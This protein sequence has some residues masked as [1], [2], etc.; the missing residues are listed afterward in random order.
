MAGITFLSLTQMGYKIKQVILE[1]AVVIWIFC[2]Y[3]CLYVY[4]WS[5]QE[6]KGGKYTKK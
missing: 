6:I 3:I 5:M 1:N 2:G 4:V